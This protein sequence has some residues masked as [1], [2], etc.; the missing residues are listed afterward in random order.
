[1]P[2][3]RVRYVLTLDADYQPVIDVQKWQRPTSDKLVR[4]RRRVLAAASDRGTD[5]RRFPLCHK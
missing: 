4:R 3:S 5:Y 2:P 1:M